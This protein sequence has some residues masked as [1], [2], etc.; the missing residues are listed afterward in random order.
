ME[1]SV[2]GLQSQTAAGVAARVLVPDLLPCDSRYDGIWDNCLATL[3]EL[4]PLID[5]LNTE[6]ADA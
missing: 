4:C 6:E 1:D 5:R 3:H 2:A